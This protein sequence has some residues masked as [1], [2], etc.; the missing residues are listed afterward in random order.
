MAITIPT[1]APR[2][3]R[4]ME[5]VTWTRTLTD[6]TAADSWA[7]SVDLAGPDSTD[8]FS[9]AGTDAGSGLW[10]FLFETT[11]KAIGEYTWQVWAT[12]ST[13]KITRSPA[14]R[15]HVFQ[16]PTSSRWN[17]DSRGAV[18]PNSPQSRAASSPVNAGLSRGSH[19]PRPIRARHGNQI[20]ADPALELPAI[21]PGIRSAPAQLGPGRRRSALWQL[22]RVE[23]VGR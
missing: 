5:R 3:A 11:D 22:R 15:F 23:V 21:A 18:D 6:Y 10:T 13:R 4:Y 2:S 9:V 12:K 16:W 7:V 14:G 1:Q 19:D 17:A 8:G 20:N